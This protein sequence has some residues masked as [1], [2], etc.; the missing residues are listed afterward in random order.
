MDRR[1]SN[2]RFHLTSYIATTQAS[3]HTS[4]LVSQLQAS[5]DP[6]FAS[7]IQRDL[8]PATVFAGLDYLQRATGFPF[9]RLEVS[10]VFIS[11]SN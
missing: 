11:M 6:A 2:R 3:A 4:P 7:Q 5:I 8:A 9:S 1:N 10:V